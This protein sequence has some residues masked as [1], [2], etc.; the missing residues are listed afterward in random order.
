MPRASLLLDGTDGLG[1]PLTG[2]RVTLIGRGAA[3]APARRRCGASWRAIRP[4]RAMPASP[5]SPST[6]WQ[7]AGGT[8]HRRLRPHRR[9]G[10]RRPAHAGRRRAGAD[11]GRAGHHR[12]HEQRPRRCGRALCNR[13]SPDAP[14]GAWR[15]VGID[16]GRAPICCIAPMPPASIFRAPVRTPGEARDALVALVQQRVRGR[17]ARVSV[18]RI[19]LTS[20]VRGVAARRRVTRVALH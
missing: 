4:P 13:S 19:A 2:G 14:A 18:A 6:R 20:R 5:I 3:D 16:P 10:R 15:M 11:R 8:L 12:A 9:P 1:D 17:R 7:V